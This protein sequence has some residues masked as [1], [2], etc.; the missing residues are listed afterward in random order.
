MMK[1][2]NGSSSRVPEKAVIQ[3]RC[4]YS[5][6]RHRS[7]ISS[8]DQSVSQMGDEEKILEKDCR[9][10][11]N[12]SSSSKRE[13]PE[14]Y[15][16][17]PL[18]EFALPGCVHSLALQGN[19][20]ASDSPSRERRDQGEGRGTCSRMGLYAGAGSQGPEVELGRGSLHEFPWL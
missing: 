17:S 16:S 20:E 2:E 13:A 18:C 3:A 7:E 15:F 1:G 8:P 11:P 9:D 6:L 14:F 4:Q 5:E 10:T 12:P 19:L